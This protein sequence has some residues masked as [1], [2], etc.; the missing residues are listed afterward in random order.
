MSRTRSTR[1]L[2]LRAD[3]PHNIDTARSSMASVRMV[4]PPSAA[5]TVTLFEEFEAGLDSGPQA[6]STPHNTV[7]HKSKYHQEHP[8]LPS[9]SHVTN[10]SANRR[11]SIVYIKSDD[12]GPSTTPATIAATPSRKSSFAQWSS[13]AVRPLMP[14]SGKLQRKISAAQP[15]S[16]GGGLRPLTLLRE[17]DSNAVEQGE[18][19]PLSLGKKHKSRAGP[20][21]HDEN[22]DPDPA[23]KQHKNLKSLQLARSETSKMRGVIMKE[24]PLP[25]VVIRPPSEV[26]TG[27]AY[28]RD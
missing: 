3:V 21:A 22:V 24:E 16:P 19:R 28:S 5:S 23:A 8:P 4:P 14:K 17:R 7:T 15:G 9:S 18:T 20:S 2:G 13:R 1:S 10:T 6:E 27:F 12:D 11:S 26:H 25:D